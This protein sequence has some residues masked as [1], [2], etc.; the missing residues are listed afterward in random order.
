MTFR[1]SIAAACAAAAFA[2]SA[3][4]SALAQ[5]TL[6]A[7]IETPAVS[8]T[9]ETLQSFAMAFIEVARISQEYQPQLQTA[10]PEDQERVRMEAGERMVEAVEAVDGISVDEYQ[11]I[12]AAAQTDPELAQRINAQITQMAPQ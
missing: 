3:P 2:I 5:E 7:P 8:V 9:D 1:N 4:V 12:M 6:P 11:Q 10:A